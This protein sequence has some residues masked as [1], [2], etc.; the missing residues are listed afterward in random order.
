MLGVFKAPSQLEAIRFANQLGNSGAHPA[1]YAGHHR[2]N[3]HV[4]LTTMNPFR[5]NM[6]QEELHQAVSL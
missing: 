5:F 6:E 3:H 4:L 2:S 1:A